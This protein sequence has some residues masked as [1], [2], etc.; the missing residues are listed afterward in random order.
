M[1]WWI[2]IHPTTILGCTLVFIQQLI[3]TIEVSEPTSASKQWWTSKPHM[4][5]Q[6][7]GAGSPKRETNRE[8][9]NLF[10]DFWPLFWTTCKNDSGIEKLFALDSSKKLVLKVSPRGIFCCLEEYNMCCELDASEKYFGASISNILMF[11]N[12]NPN[13][14]C[15]TIYIYI[16][17]YI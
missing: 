6:Q 16:H 7:A 11:R 10:T 12:V 5:L 9:S 15:L 13:E 14:L 2:D 3:M 8:T 4:R 1:Y 17:I